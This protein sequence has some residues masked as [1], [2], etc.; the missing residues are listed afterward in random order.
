MDTNKKLTKI[1]LKLN[2]SLCTLW[3]KLLHL[4]VVKFFS[5]KRT[6][7]KGISKNTE[8]KNFLFLDSFQEGNKV[9]QLL[10]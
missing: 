5:L 4:S 7:G 3:L 2:T 6:Q 9:N 8:E 10:I 1:I